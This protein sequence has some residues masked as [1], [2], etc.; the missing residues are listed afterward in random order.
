MYIYLCIY[1]EYYGSIGPHQQTT[2]SQTDRQYKRN[3]PTTCDNMCVVVC[4]C[5]D[6]ERVR[7]AAMND[8]MTF[9]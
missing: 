9:E 3:P 6:C 7:K 1:R 2:P 4:E 8:K 5:E